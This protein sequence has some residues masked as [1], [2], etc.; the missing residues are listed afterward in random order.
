MKNLQ[1]EMYY[2]IYQTLIVNQHQM[3]L[4]MGQIPIMSQYITLKILIQNSYDIEENY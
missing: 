2:L 1:L 4:F 3:I